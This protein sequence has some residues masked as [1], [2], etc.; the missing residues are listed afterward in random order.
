[1]KSLLNVGGG[2]KGIPIPTYF[3]GWKHDLLDISPAGKPDVVMDAR[4]LHRLPAGSYDAVYCS[5]NLEHYHRA[6]GAKVVRGFHHVLKDDGFAEIRVPDVL[7]VIRHVAAS[8]M[9]LDDV[10]YHAPVGP[11]LVRDVLYGY[12]VE[13][14]QYGNEFY[15]HK[16]G[17]SPRSLAQFLAGAGFELS[18]VGSHAPFEITAYLFKR[19]PGPEL[20]TMLGISP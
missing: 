5:H 15:A 13:V 1:V 20:R 6:D 10:L 17:F 3:D 19:S 11:I 2:S 14:E 12:H 9:D 16:T 7:S 4:E 8:N 18:G